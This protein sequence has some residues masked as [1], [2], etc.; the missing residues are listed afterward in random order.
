M[1]LLYIN[2][3]S[4]HITYGMALFLFF[5]TTM[6]I[7]GYQERKLKNDDKSVVNE[8]KSTSKQTSK[9]K[10]TEKIIV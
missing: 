10:Q 8:L 6:E 9:L 2:L 5:K 4:I 1:H 7:H 3:W